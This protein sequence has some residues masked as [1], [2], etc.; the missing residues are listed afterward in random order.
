[1]AV[2]ALPIGV[3]ARQRLA[4][5]GAL[6]GRGVGHP[7]A[8]DTVDQSSRLAQQGLAQGAIPGAARGG[9]GH[10]PLMQVI[11]QPEKIRQ[12]VV[13]QPLEQRQHELPIAGVDK[14]VGV[15]NPFANAMKVDQRTNVVTGQERL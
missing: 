3:Q 15:L 12:L 14:V 9:R 7:D 8:G 13:V 2:K 5:R 11:H 10:A 1:M 4:D 6:P